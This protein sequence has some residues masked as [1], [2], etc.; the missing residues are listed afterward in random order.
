MRCLTLCL[1]VACQSPSKGDDAAG[2]EPDSPDSA[3]SGSSPFDPN[4]STTIGPTDRPVE[5]VL[6]SSYDHTRS[7]PVVVMLHGYSATAALQDVIFGLRAR[8]E[9]M[10]FILVA[11]DGLVDSYGNQYWNAATECCDFDE[12]GVDDV[13]Y[14]SGLI[15]EAQ[16]LYPVS[17]VAVMGHSNG[18]FMSY[19]MACER[20]E[21]VDR[22][23]SLA[24]TL[25]AVPAECPRSE[26]VRVLHMHGTRDTSVRY[27]SF[28]GHNGARDSITHFTELGGCTGPTVDGQRDHIRDVD[29]AETTV[30]IWDCPDGDMQLWTGEG[31][32]HVYLSA[33]DDYRDQLATWL[34]AP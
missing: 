1:L 25:S 21:L 18:G 14:I 23:A 22:I 27:E 32:D 28:S 5:V 31:G 19:R 2:S 20:P 4:P 10:D 7:Y 17:H 12:T 34:S 15:E 13:G 24:G 3:D 8:V 29:G 30:E 9:T 6:P 16:S 11:P 26:A 33:N